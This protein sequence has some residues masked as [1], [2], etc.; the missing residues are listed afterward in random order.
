MRSGGTRDSGVLRLDLATRAWTGFAHDPADPASLGDDRISALYVDG[1][2]RLWVGTEGG[3][4]LLDSSPGFTHF[5]TN[6]ADGSSLSD[7]KVRAIL[8]DDTGA[9]W[10]GT[11]NGGLNKLDPSTGRFEHFRHDDAV[12]SS[13]AHDHV[14][15]ILQDAD[16]RLWI[17]TNDGLDLFDQVHHTFAH[18]RQD[19]KNPFSLAENRSPPRSFFPSLPS[20]PPATANDAAPSATKTAIIAP[21]NH[22]VCR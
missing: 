20:P 15:A 11:S 7:G 22:R 5:V 18:Y 1:K 10:V 8:Q 12:R 9:L 19:A 13:L 3:L 16:G 4:D 17:G 14:K 6:P 2:G 21:T